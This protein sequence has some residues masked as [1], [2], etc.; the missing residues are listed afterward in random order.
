VTLLERNPELFKTWK[1]YRQSRLLSSPFS[2][3]A[4]PGPHLPQVPDEVWPDVW[5]RSDRGHLWIHQPAASFISFRAEGND[6]RNGSSRH[7]YRPLYV[8]HPE[9][10]LGSPPPAL[11]FL[12]HGNPLGQRILSGAVCGRLAERELIREHWSPCRGGPDELPGSAD[13]RHR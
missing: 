10:T 4:I 1:L 11:P 7:G 13:V 5:D 6:L 2:W 9:R 8:G 12:D 3:R